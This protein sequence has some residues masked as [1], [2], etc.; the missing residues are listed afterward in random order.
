[1]CH[2]S[3]FSSLK[4]FSLT[5]LALSTGQGGFP[6]YAYA[7]RGMLAFFPTLPPHSPHA[8]LRSRNIVQTLRTSCEQIP[9]EFRVVRRVGSTQRTRK[10]A[11]SPANSSQEPIPLVSMDTFNYDQ[12]ATHRPLSPLLYGK[13]VQAH[14]SQDS[15]QSSCWTD[16]GWSGAA[17]ICLSLVHVY[18]VS[19]A[20]KVLDWS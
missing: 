8:K 15:V 10:R 5:H 2:L 1:M 13:A 3:S 17:R 14:N 9:K 4:S 16:I 18:C 20:C 6:A 19:T 11:P 7:R 12:N